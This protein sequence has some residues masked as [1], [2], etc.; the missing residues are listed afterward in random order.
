M[1]K[2][3]LCEKCYYLL[4]ACSVTCDYPRHLLTK[5]PSLLIC[6]LSQYLNANSPITL[7]WYGFFVVVSLECFTLIS[8]VLNSWFLVIHTIQ[9]CMKYIKLDNYQILLSDHLMSGHFRFWVIS[10]R[11]RLGIGSSNVGLFYGFQ[12]ISNW[13]R[14]DIRSVSVGSFQI[15]GRVE[16]GIRSSSIRSFQVLANIRLGWV[17]YQIF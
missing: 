3:H 9:G 2:F 8:I 11:V 1:F 4:C 6:V 7:S 10:D 12:V 14:S 5:D 17:G 16:S 13:V 15:S